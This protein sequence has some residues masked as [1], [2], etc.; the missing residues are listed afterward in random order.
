M[1]N[2]IKL[3]IVI[4]AIF[5]VASCKKDNPA[6]SNTGN[7]VN[8]G[9]A[10]Q[11][12]T[13]SVIT[14]LGGVDDT[15]TTTFAYDTQARVVTEIIVTS[16]AGMLAAPDTITYTYTATTVV[17]NDALNG[18]TTY[19]LNG[20]GYRVSDNTGDSWTYNSSG[21]L[22]QSIFSGNNTSY[23][24]NSLN[25]L[26]TQ[27]QLQLG[28]AA[29]TDTFTYPANP[30]IQQ[31]PTWS[32]GKSTGDL[33]TTDVTVQNGYPTTSTFTYT[34]NSQGKLTEATETSGTSGTVISTTYYTYY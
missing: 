24:Y 32:T 18:S 11:V 29:V 6:T 9:S 27:T 17:Q 25:Q 16:H 31:G 33:Y 14:S 5:A 10:G 3:F 7:T 30:V 2:K 28:G 1:R 23:T 4:I 21:Y 8:T 15:I 20:A 22:T 26:A 19:T 13:S 12:K 34:T